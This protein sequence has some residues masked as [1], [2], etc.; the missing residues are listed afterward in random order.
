MMTVKGLISALP[1]GAR[2]KIQKL[3]FCRKLQQAQIDDEVELA[4]IPRLIEPGMT[5]F[6]IGANFGL[7]TRFLSTATGPTGRVFSFEPTLDMFEVLTNNT[8]ALELDNVVTSQLALSEG[9]KE[10]TFY[11]PKRDD[12]TLNYYEA[13]LERDTIGSEHETV[14]VMTT[15][16]D[17]FC[18]DGDITSVD[19]IKIDVEGHELAVLEGA[20][21]VIK[22]DRPPIFL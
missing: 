1:D 18:E 4:I 11:I 15:S 8:I 9:Q 2:R 22:R 13:S 19:F 5:A 7:Y 12:G 17:Q 16:L 21:K 3:H 6:D 10:L 20:R 14:V